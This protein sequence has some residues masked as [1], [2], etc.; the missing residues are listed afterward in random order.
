MNHLDLKRLQAA[1]HEQELTEIVPSPDILTMF[2]VPD[3]ESFM[4]YMEAR[5]ETQDVTVDWSGDVELTI[6]FAELE[7]WISCLTRA[8][9]LLM[10]AKRM[11]KAREK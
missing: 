10:E 5:P 4:L 3:D 6:P 2:Y 8:R 1:F 11:I 9:A 7:A